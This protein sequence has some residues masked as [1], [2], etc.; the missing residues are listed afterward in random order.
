MV[1]KSRRRGTGSSVD[2]E[3]ARSTA[4]A[5]TETLLRFAC[6]Q[7]R[8]NVVLLHALEGQFIKT[9]RD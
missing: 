6:K 4:L 3:E 8:H 9:E 2:S 7:D 5:R 1:Q